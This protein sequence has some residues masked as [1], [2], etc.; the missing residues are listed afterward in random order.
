MIVNGWWIKLLWD[1]TC[2]HGAQANQMAVI[3][4]IRYYVTSNNISRQMRTATIF[5]KNK[6]SLLFPNL[7]LETSIITHPNGFIYSFRNRVS[8]K[9]GLLE[10]DKLLR[11]KCQSIKIVFW[12]HVCIYCNNVF[13]VAFNT[14]KY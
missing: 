12:L 10:C 8:L 13:N 9:S 11:N 1:P 3:T 4:R 6:C 14:T 2:M 7:W 5:M